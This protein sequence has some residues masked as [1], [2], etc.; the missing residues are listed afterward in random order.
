M[1]DQPEM[2][3]EVSSY[4]GCN[5]YLLYLSCQKEFTTWLVK[6]AAKFREHV[7]EHTD[8]PAE[9]H[10]EHLEEYADA[11]GPFRARTIITYRNLIRLA[12][13]V[14][15]H[16]MVP[17]RMLNP[18]CY[19]IS[20]RGDWDPGNQK[21]PEIDMKKEARDKDTESAHIHV[22]AMST[23]RIVRDILL[24]APV[25]TEPSNDPDI[26]N[27]STVN[28]M[29]TYSL[30]ALPGEA[31]FAWVC[32]FNDLF[33][34]RS[35]LSAYWHAYRQGLETLTTRTLVTNTAIRQMRDNCDIQI[36]ATRHLPDMPPEWLINEWI[37][38]GVTGDFS[39]KYELD[40]WQ[41][42]ESSWCCYEA[43]GGVILFLVD[44][45][46][47]NYFRSWVMIREAGKDPFKLYGKP[48]AHRI[49]IS[50][51][52]TLLHV[53]SGF[54]HQDDQ[55]F[56]PCVDEITSGWMTWDPYL[57]P[58]HLPLW[59]VL[60]LQIWL[61]TV[62]TLGD[63]SPT[64]LDDLK[65]Q[66]EDQVSLIRRFSKHPTARK[67][68][69]DGNKPSIFAVVQVVARC[70]RRDNFR[71]KAIENLEPEAKEMAMAPSVD[72]FFQKN[73]PLLCG[74]QSWWLEQ[75]YRYFEWWAIRL[76]ECIA[77]AAILYSSMY[78]L[79]LVDLWPDMASV[80]LMRAPEL[81]LLMPENEG[82]SGRC[83]DKTLTHCIEK[84]LHYS[85]CYMNLHKAQKSGERNPISRYVANMFE[86]YYQPDLVYRSPLAHPI[87]GA[88]PPIKC[89][90]EIIAN[91][92]DHPEYKN[93]QAREKLT[94]LGLPNDLEVLELVTE[95]L[96]QDEAL[97]AF[98]W[99]SMHDRCQTFLD[100]LRSKFMDNYIVF[101]S[102]NP[103]DLNYTPQSPSDG[104]YSLDALYFLLF[105]EVSEDHID[106]LG[107]ASLCLDPSKIAQYDLTDK[108]Y[109]TERWKDGIVRHAKELGLSIQLAAT[110]LQPLIK[111]EGNVDCFKSIERHRK[112][113]KKRGKPSKLNA[114]QLKS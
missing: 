111:R 39:Q 85:Q 21:R 67:K 16:G 78:R 95:S 101:K 40:S 80:I 37:Y 1:P 35:Y 22:I 73:H 52:C 45:P 64:A 57:D 107:L 54:A 27:P 55:P 113:Y 98:D 83:S 34:V 41:S 51:L 91:Q 28:A 79:N 112:Y 72:F 12:S 70:I 99:V 103:N 89:A 24:S 50:V 23:L 81:L 42:Y 46:H 87:F 49:F 102:K 97:S 65:E 26:R 96:Y 61:D 32:F 92:L 11:T 76:H 33:V 75:E 10:A 62:V 43:L 36:Q 60:S 68:D 77:P 82:L 104:P 13:V 69:R 56:L 93:N 105:S 5:S 15:H 9:A 30:P 14:A 3:P 53:L 71:K 106:N 86:C 94:L 66:A 44:M 4:T 19:M 31:F 8:E 108:L 48:L 38:K 109:L 90:H 84:Q 20:L 2:P 17:R 18:L 6:A 100:N 114:S 29:E 58:D 59:L 25:D 7:E 63:Y 88:D 110:V 47:F 74:M